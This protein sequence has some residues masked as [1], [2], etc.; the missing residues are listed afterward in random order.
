MVTGANGAVDFVVMG[1]G[2]LNG[3]VAV[4]HGLDSDLERAWL[5]YAAQSFRISPAT[6]AGLRDRGLCMDVIAAFLEIQARRRPGLSALL[7]MQ[8]DGWDWRHIA[9]RFGLNTDEIAFRIR[10][11]ECH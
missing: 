9:R 5:S 7:R 6:I 10:R 3:L 8:H 2:E 11:F 4:A 1:H